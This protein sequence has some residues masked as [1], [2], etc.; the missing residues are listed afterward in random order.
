MGMTI[1]THPDSFEVD[2]FTDH[3]SHR[4]DP[5]VIVWACESSAK[6]S[7]FMKTPALCDELIKAAVE[8]KRLLLGEPVQPVCGA[9]AE[10]TG[11]TCEL[12]AGHKEDPAGHGDWHRAGQIVWP[13]EPAQDLP[14]AEADPAN[15]YS[16]S[17]HG[18]FTA[19]SVAAVAED[20]DAS[21]L[22]PTGHL[23]Q[24]KGGHLECTLCGQPGHH[25]HAASI[26]ADGAR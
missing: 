8:A 4:E 10:H 20:V 16:S 2:D 26:A 15:P 12:P 11:V 21:H 22:A 13:Q 17:K 23:P 3:P 7:L 14:A 19:T 9:V 24:H 25:L 6:V 5:F 18:E 1:Q